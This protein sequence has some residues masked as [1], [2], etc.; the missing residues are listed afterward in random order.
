MYFHVPR[1]IVRSGLHPKSSSGAKVSA[2]RGRRLDVGIWELEVVW[3]LGVGSWRLTPSESNVPSPASDAMV[4]AT[5][6]KETGAATTPVCSPAP[7]KMSGT[8]T[9]VS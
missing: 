8:R 3:E 7:L 2:Y 5:S 1:R 4:G 9:V 6:T